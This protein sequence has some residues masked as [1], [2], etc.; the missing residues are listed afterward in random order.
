MIYSAVCHRC[1]KLRSIIAADSKGIIGRSWEEAAVATPQPPFETP[2]AVLSPNDAATLRATGAGTLL[3]NSHN[4]SSVWRCKEDTKRNKV[5][6][7]PSKTVQ[8]NVDL[9]VRGSSRREQ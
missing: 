6:R 9:K 7:S 5:E 4:R 2:S 8:V 3:T 1:H